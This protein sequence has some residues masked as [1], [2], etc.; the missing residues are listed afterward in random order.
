M[1]GEPFQNPDQAEDSLADVIKKACAYEKEDRYNS[2]MLM[3]EDLENLLTNLSDFA[4]SKRVT[5][6]ES[7]D[8]SGRQT[9]LSTLSTGQ[10]KIV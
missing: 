8:A 7:N 6:L 2:P 3:K 1:R 4:K 5:L 9:K 10:K